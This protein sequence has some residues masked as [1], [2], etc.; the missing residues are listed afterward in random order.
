MEVDS[1][2]VYNLVDNGNTAPSDYFQLLLSIQEP[3][4]RE[5][6]VELKH[7]YC[8]ANYATDALAN[9][10]LSLPLGLHIFC[11]H[12]FLLILLLGVICMGLPIPDLFRLSPL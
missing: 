7:I 2:C 11:S 3:L 10:A 6:T 1:L 12:Q 4:R 5:W 8:E 9:Y